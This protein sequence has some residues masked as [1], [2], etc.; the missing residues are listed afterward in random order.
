[1]DQS[2]YVILLQAIA[3]LAV[4][5]APSDLQNKPGLYIDDRLYI[6]ESA[7]SQILANVKISENIQLCDLVNTN[8]P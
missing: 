4:V 1:M 7:R 3:V 5:L 8:S 2:N 6:Y